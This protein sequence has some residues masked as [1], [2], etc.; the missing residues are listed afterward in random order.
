MPPTLQVPVCDGNAAFN[1]VMRASTT[2]AIGEFVVLV[3][4]LKLQGAPTLLFTWLAML[5]S[6]LVG[7]CCSRQPSGAHR[8]VPVLLL[9]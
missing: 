6:S 8:R 5:A 3:K 9:E 2:S 1:A 4:T 7:A